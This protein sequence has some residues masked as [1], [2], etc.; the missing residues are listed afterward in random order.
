MADGVDVFTVPSGRRIRI[1]TS[2]PF[3][4]DCSIDCPLPLFSILRMNALC[5]FFPKPTCLF[6]VEAIYAIPFL[7]ESKASPPAT[8][9]ANSPYARASVASAR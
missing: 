1:S 3:F 6:L 8:P 7:G 9:Q 2:Y 4:T 5:L